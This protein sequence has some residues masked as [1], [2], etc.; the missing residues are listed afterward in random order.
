MADELTV[1]D[2]VTGRAASEL[3]EGVLPTN[4][5]LLVST[6][7]EDGPGFRYVVSHGTPSTL[8]VGMLRSATLKVEDDDLN[9][10]GGDDE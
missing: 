3:G 5:I 8:I 10:W 6:I 9:G 2:L 1:D 7:S 4:A